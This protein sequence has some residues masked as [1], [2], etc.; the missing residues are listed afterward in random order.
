MFVE[1]FK[2]DKFCSFRADIKQAENVI[3]YMYTHIELSLK[4]CQQ[5]VI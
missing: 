2:F 4:T 5:S 3:L 1:Y